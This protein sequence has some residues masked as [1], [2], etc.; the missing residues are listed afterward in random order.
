MSATDPASHRRFVSVVITILIVC[1]IGAAIEGTGCVDPRYS[2]CKMYAGFFSHIPFYVLGAI[3]LSEFWHRGGVSKLRKLSKLRG[4]E[5]ALSKNLD[6]GKAWAF[7]F[8]KAA[9]CLFIG[10][11]TVGVI[12]T[13]I[14][15]N[16]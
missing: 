8:Q 7:N 1:S 15:L 9:E 10:L 14:W 6:L 2:S 12:F 3:A 16:S 13:W 4:A 11:L 5:T